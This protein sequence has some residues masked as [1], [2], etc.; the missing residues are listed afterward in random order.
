VIEKIKEE[1]ISIY[2]K[3]FTF[4]DAAGDKP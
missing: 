2:D 1:D 3:Q 4:M